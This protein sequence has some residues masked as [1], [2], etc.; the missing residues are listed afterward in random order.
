MK[1]KLTLLLLLG[2]LMAGNLIAD[3]DPQFLRVDN[4]RAPSAL[5]PGVVAEAVNLAF[6]RGQ[7]HT[8]PGVNCQRWGTQ[9]DNLIPADLSLDSIQGTAAPRN[10]ASVG[11]VTGFVVGRRYVFLPGNMS[12]L[13]AAT[14]PDSVNGQAPD[15]ATYRAYSIFVATQTSYFLTKIDPARFTG[16]VTAQIYA[17]GRPCGYGRFSDP[18]GIDNAVLLTDDDRTGGGEDGGKGRAWRIVPGNVPQEIPL[19]GHDIWDAARLIQCFNGLVLLRQG[20]ERHY[21]P[22][23]AFNASDSTIQLNAVPAW[24]SGDVV[25]IVAADA[26]SGI[27]H[28]PNLNAAY[29]VC[30]VDGAGK[31]ALYTTKTLAVAAGTTGLV[32]WTSV[33]GRFYVQLANGPAGPWGNGAPPLILQGT[34]VETPFEVGFESVQA[35]VVIQGVDTGTNLITAHNHRFIPGDHVKF[36]GVS[37]TGS[38]DVAQL[39][40]APQDDHSFLVYTNEDDA[41]ADDG[42]TNIVA[43]ASVSNGYCFKVGAAGLPMPPGREGVY[44]KQR[45]IIVNGR[46]NV[47]ISDPLDPLHFTLDD[48]INANLGEADQVN[49]LVPLGDDALMINKENSVLAFTGLSGDSSGWALQEVTREYGNQSPL[50]AL[51]FGND[52]WFGARNGVA[53]IAQTE[54]GKTQGTAVPVSNDIAS[55]FTSVDWRHAGQA[56]GAVWNNRFYSAWPLR[57]QS[58]ANDAAPA[59]NGLFVFNALNN[60]WEDLWQGAMLTPVA[61]V[62]LTIAGEERLSFVNAAGMVCWLGDGFTDVTGPIATRLVTRG[63]FG[64]QR[65]LAR[66]ATTDWDTY[67]ADLTVKV[68]AP[69]WH[70]EYTAG[71]YTPDRTKSL[72]DGVADYDPTGSDAASFQASGRQDYRKSAHELLFG[73]GDIHQNT[74]LPWRFRVRDRS[75]Q[76]IVENAAG[77]VRLNGITLQASRLDVVATQES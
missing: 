66:R 10:W 54:L 20:D 34:P 9:S 14:K 31:I 19:N 75:P 67:A 59:N 71:T 62:R 72:R 37:W 56:C 36:S 41:L 13:S 58:L 18:N 74:C 69:G 1:A 76:L 5:E 46:N 16:T 40:V 30:N 55:R 77:S 2:V 49:S 45:L 26:G 68:R 47:L 52:V 42:A 7:A 64:L 57:G 35:D 53:S 44:Y 70:E 4:R 50:L 28:G 32:G 29:Y 38:P 27:F 63:Y 21:V 12:Y 48:N 25:K 61:F 51:Q 23:A 24:Q 15:G 33:E 3:A 73:P 43:P 8:R 6:D 22:A 17:A 39:Y 11:T 60:G 65:V